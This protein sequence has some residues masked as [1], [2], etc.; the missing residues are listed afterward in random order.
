VPVRTVYTYDQAKYGAQLTRLLTFKNNEEHKLGKEPLP[1]GTVR[2]Y[3]AHG[4]NRLGFVG[5]VTTDYIAKNDEVKVNAGPDPEVSMKRKRLAFKKEN[6]V[7]NWVNNRQYIA[8]W[9]T[10]EDFEIELANYRGRPVDFEIN[11]SFDGDFDFTSTAEAAT[12]DYRTRRFSTS[13]AAGGRLKIS[14][15]VRTRF[16]TNI[17]NK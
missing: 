12:V 10:V 4:D 2:L 6:L 13:I 11:V 14:Y 17:R 8:G 3:K 16:G 9:D 5:A 15:N 1:A 7:F